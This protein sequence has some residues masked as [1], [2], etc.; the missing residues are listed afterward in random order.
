MVP[1]SSNPNQ[2]SYVQSIF[3]E[4]FIVIDFLGAMYP[5]F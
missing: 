2:H 1:Y 4:E 5:K 3:N